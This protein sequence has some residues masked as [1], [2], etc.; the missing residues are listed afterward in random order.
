MFFTNICKF[1]FLEEDALFNQQ[2]AVDGVKKTSLESN[3]GS[4]SPSPF[5]SPKH[6]SRRSCDWAPD[7]PNKKPRSFLYILISDFLHAF[8]R[9]LWY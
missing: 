4:D 6:G 8:Y 5:S 7:T 3:A 2:N 9:H 1:I